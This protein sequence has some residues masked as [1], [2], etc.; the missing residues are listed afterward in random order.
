MSTNWFFEVYVKGP[1]PERVTGWD[2]KVGYVVGVP[3]RY[4]ALKR[5]DAHFGE[6][7]DVVIQCYQTVVSNFNDV[8][9]GYI[10]LR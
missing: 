5:I 8:G 10:V 3:T 4:D 9:S 6:D 1:P 2:I 7:F